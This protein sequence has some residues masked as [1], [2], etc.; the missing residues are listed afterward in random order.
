M[1]DNLTWEIFSSFEVTFWKAVRYDSKMMSNANFMD[2]QAIVN[3]Y[4]NVNLNNEV[5]KTIEVLN[6]LEI[7]YPK[8]SIE[9]INI[10]E[11]L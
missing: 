8:E 5:M 1:V 2:G 3:D 7:N 4:E 11:V 10:M 9:F 6:I